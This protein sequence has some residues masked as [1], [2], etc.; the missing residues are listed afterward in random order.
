MPD[1][2]LA[3]RDVQEC[4]QRLGTLDLLN[5][6]SPAAEQQYFSSTARRVRAAGRGLARD[7]Q[8]R[9]RASTPPTMAPRRRSCR[10]PWSRSC[11]CRRSARILARVLG[12]YFVDTDAD[13]DEEYQYCIVGV[14]AAAGPAAG[15]H[16]GR[17]ADWGAGPWYRRAS[18]G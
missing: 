12:L 3:N 4:G 8:L 17:R 14:W 10:C 15:A 1:P 5:G 11:R 9:R 7:T 2:V 18:T 6:M 16:P 13:P